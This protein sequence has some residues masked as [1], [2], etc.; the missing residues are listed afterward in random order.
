ML[1]GQTTLELANQ[2]ALTG[3]G[4]WTQNGG[5]GKEKA[6]PLGRV[7][8]AP[9]LVLGPFSPLGINHPV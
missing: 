5:G 1:M 2:S 7:C 8:Y 3:L 6:P 4:S 9:G